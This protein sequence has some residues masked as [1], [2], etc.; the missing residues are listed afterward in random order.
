VISASHSLLQSYLLASRFA[1]ESLDKSTYESRHKYFIPMHYCF[2]PNVFQTRAFY[3]FVYLVIQFPIS[4]C[5][6]V[7][8]SCFYH[9]LVSVL[10]LYQTFICA[11]SRFCFAIVNNY[12]YIY[13]WT[14]QEV[15]NVLLVGT[16]LGSITILL[17]E[18]SN[19]AEQII[20]K[21]IMHIQSNIDISNSDITHSAK[22]EGSIW[23]INTFWLLSPTII[24]RWRL[25]LQVQITQSEN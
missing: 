18:K 14:L 17:V 12:Q 5:L 4:V 25:F 15:L 3:V 21:L 2:H 1:N 20:E 16:Y 7:C 9:G 24:W 22:L 8:L 11:Q 19:I 13:I 6:Y 10:S 23:I